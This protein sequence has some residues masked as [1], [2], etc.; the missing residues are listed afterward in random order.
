MVDDDVDG[1][2]IWGK[3]GVDGGRKTQIYNGGGRRIS[4]LV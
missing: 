1:S 3:E 4:D 2:R